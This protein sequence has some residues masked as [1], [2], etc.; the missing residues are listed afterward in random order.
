[1]YGVFGQALIRWHQGR[2]HKAGESYAARESAPSRP[3]WNARARHCRRWADSTWPW[4]TSYWSRTNWNR[5]SG[6]CGK[7]WI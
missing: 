1:V 7:A 3:S 2:L 5:R 6:R 4:A